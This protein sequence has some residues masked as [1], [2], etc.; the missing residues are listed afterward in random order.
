MGFSGQEYWSGLPCP[1]PG[2]LPDPEIKPTSPALAGGFFVTAPQGLHTW[3]LKYWFTAVSG[4][5]WSLGSSLRMAFTVAHGLQD[6]LCRLSGSVAAGPRL[7]C[8]AAYGIFIP[9]PGIEPE[10]P[11]WK[12]SS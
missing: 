6:R 3:F 8:L 7:S 10:S 2:D 4:L 5:L 1:S 11:A 9:Q 12:V